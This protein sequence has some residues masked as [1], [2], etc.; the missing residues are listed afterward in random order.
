MYK[1]QTVSL[2]LIDNGFAEIQFDNQGESVNKFNQA[3]LA[4]LREAVD[5]LKAQM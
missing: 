3:T 5:T 4:D 2:T 1:G